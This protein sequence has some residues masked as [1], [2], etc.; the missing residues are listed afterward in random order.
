MID[1][2]IYSKK[3]VTIFNGV[4]NLIKKGDNLYTIKVSD[5]AKS[6]DIGKGTIYDYFGSKE[7]TIS[8]ALIYYMNSEMESSYNRIMIKESFKEKYYEILLIIKDSYKSNLF[9]VSSILSS[10][11]LKELY[12]HLADE[13]C[14]TN[15]FFSSINNIIVHLLETGKKD[16][17]V[18]VE[19]DFYYFVMAIRGSVSTFSHYIGKKEYYKDINVEKA[20]DTSYKILLKSLK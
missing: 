16:G 6:A 17:I 1:K 14:N 11:G 19:E 8:K 20:M 2:K 7:E 9:I 5:I 12:K 10:A 13:G 18:T 3:E 15:Y 4:I